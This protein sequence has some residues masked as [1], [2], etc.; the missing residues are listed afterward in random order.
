MSEEIY[1]NNKIIEDENSIVRNS[2]K[3][4]SKLLE[5]EINNKTDS[6]IKEIK[7]YTKY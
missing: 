2:T 1:K 5:L 6:K 3:K 4:K 7:E